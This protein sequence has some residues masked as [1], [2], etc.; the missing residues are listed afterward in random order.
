MNE[1]KK[2]NQQNGQKMITE[3]PSESKRQEDK[4]TYNKFRSVGDDN[5]KN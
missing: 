5:S 2:T 4:S 3:N 1:K